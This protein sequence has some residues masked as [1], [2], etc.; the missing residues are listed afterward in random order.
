[1]SSSIGY[2]LLQDAASYDEMVEGCGLECESPLLSPEEY[3]RLKT[4]IGI[5]GT[6]CLGRP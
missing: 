1:M 4:F 2:R 3:T 6:I 5:A